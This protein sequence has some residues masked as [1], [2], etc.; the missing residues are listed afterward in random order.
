MAAQDS[1]AEV[2]AEIAPTQNAVITVANVRQVPLEKIPTKVGEWDPI[3]LEVFLEVAE[4]LF[5]R[6]G[7]LK[8]VMDE[9]VICEQLCD[10][11]KLCLTLP[12]ITDSWREKPE[13]V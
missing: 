10:C 2:P 11:M 8:F 5:S 6:W 4:V 7:L 9:Q 1:A 3:A 13:K 12:A